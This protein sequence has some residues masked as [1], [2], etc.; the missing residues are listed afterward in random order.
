MN[1]YVLLV[2]QAIPM[3]DV[4]T[5][6]SVLLAFMTGVKT[7]LIVSILLDLMTVLAILDMK[8]IHM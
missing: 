6:M 8:E 4:Q 5:L 7:T 1:A 3:Q 2:T